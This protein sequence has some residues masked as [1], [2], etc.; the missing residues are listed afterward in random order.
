MPLQNAITKRSDYLEPSP[1]RCVQCNADLIR[2]PRRPIDWLL[3][4]FSPVLRY[5]CTRFACQWT[6][7]LPVEH[8]LGNSNAQI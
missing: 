1:Y 5:R 3:S 4:I 2:T 7:N 8:N 6:G